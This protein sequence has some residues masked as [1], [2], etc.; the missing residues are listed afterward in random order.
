MSVDNAS[1]DRH[2]PASEQR[3]VIDKCLTVARSWMGDPTALAIKMFAEFV[4]CMIFHFVGSVSG[5]ASGNAVVLMVLVY[6][7]AKMSGGHLNP[8][9]TFTFTLLGHT[10]PLEMVAYWIAQVAGC[11]VGALWLAWL[12]PGLYVRDDVSLLRG[13]GI[14]QDG[15]FVPHA[16]LAKRQ[17]W[18]W[19]AACTFCFLVPIFSVVWYTQHK[20][21]YGNTGPIIVGLSLYAAASAA[22]EWTGG[23]LNPAR[24]L[25][26]P[27]EAGAARRL[28][29]ALRNLLRR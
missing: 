26:S 4:G 16:E 23:A 11:I 7:S 12:V 19:E 18:G 3:S 10:A 29:N 21:G 13:D 17:V 6:Y 8:A 27:H 28:Q 9:V 22:G 20:S 25:A 24:V 15:C 2:S 1:N 14:F 5:T